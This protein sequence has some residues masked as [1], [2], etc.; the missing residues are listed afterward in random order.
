VA[1]LQQ[2]SWLAVLAEA[3]GGAGQAAQGLE[4]VAEAL[5][6]MGTTGE[7]YY[8]A[9]VY[10]LQGELLWQAG[11][12]PQGAETPLLQALTAARQQEAK[13]WELRAAVSLGRL[14]QQQG[15]RA[16]AYALLA[17]LYG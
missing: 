2:R 6:I 3:Y 4:A 13:S 15:N 7:R 1:H 16:E 9:E 10:R 11:T 17:P 14:W 5:A 8:A 12:Q